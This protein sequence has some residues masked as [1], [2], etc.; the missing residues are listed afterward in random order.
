MASA[1]FPIPSLFG[2][3]GARISSVGLNVPRGFSAPVFAIPML[4]LHE[5]LAGAFVPFSA[6]GRVGGILLCDIGLLLYNPP[7][8]LNNRM[9]CLPNRVE[10]RERRRSLVGL[11]TAHV[12]PAKAL[13]SPGQEQHALQV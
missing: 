8:F 9:E 4:L 2:V 11:S 13:L 5:P 10:P 7:Q 12:R 6:S 3:I 1:I